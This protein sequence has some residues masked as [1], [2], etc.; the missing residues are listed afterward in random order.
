MNL[1]TLRNVSPAAYKIC[2]LWFSIV[3]LDSI[4]G[5]GGGYLEI[6][7]NDPC[8]IFLEFLP[9]VSSHLICGDLDGSRNT[10]AKII[11]L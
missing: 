3:S 7:R 10:S 11:T 8:F 9:S 6:S 2:T 5:P 4:A 1:I